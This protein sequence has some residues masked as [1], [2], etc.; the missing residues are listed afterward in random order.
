MYYAICPECAYTTDDRERILC[1]YCR[2]ELLKQC[3]ACGKPIAEKP[4]VYC[5]E[6][7]AKMRQS[8]TPI[9]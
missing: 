9:Q 5:R 6:C 2:T 3:P 1:E 4:A 7:G 8:I